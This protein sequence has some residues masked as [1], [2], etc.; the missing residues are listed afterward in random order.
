MLPLA[1]HE[2]LERLLLARLKEQ[3]AALKKM[4]DHLGSHWIYEDGFYRFY[5]A[6]YKVYGIQQATMS[7]VQ[8]LRTLLPERKLNLSF[9][10]II[11][12]GTGKEFEMAHN[13]NWEAHTRPMLEAFSHAKFMMEM[14]VRYA[15]VSEPPRPLPSGYAALLYL[16][17]LR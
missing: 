4:L 3:K 9:E 12:E 14:A 6:S 13:E 15:D 10:K 7:A 17:D 2:R 5:H 11:S 1:E 16:F 8:L